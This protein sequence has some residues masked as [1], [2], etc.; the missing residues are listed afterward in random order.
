M[1]ELIGP[2]GES[3]DQK[4]RAQFSLGNVVEK[5]PRASGDG[6]S[7]VSGVT[8]FSQST[9]RLHASIKSGTAA[10]PTHLWDGLE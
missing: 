2:T 4:R 8:T 1:L 5:R 7:I 9:L 10:V 3:E 6:N